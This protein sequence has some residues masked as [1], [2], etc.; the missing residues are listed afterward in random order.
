MQGTLYNLTMD[1]IQKFESDIAKTKK[2]ERAAGSVYDGEKTCRKICQLFERNNP[3][4]Q[5]LAVS[6]ANYWMEKYILPSQE[7]NEEPTEKN[8]AIIVAM[9]ALMDN[10]VSLTDALSQEDWK[11]LCSLTNYE[12]EEMD[13]DKLNDLM[14]IFV[15]KNAL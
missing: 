13:M 3:D 15:D 5:A 6:W 9:Q 11:E 4:C 12:S 1:S 8:T 10:E 7:L 2:H 14:I